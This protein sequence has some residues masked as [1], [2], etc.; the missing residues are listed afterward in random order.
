MAKKKSGSKVG[1]IALL[2]LVVMLVLASVGICSAWRNTTV[3]V[4]GNS[5]T[6][7]PELP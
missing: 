6:D 5:T 3:P 1:L 4:R 7:C 2:V